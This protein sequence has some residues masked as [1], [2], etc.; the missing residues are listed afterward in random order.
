MA[1]RRIC[2]K[3]D[4]YEKD[5]QTKGKY[6]EVG[7]ILSGEKGDYILLDPTVSL[8]GLLVRQRLMDPKKAGKTIICSI[9]ES[10]QKQKPQTQQAGPPDEFDDEIPF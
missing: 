4:T 7:V 8:S 3:V 5:G 10:E 2:A 1:R 9:F 6:V